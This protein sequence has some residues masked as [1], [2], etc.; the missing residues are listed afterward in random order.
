LGGLPA[1]GRARPAARG[2][3]RAR[4]GPLRRALGGA[5]DWRRLALVFATASFVETV[6][7]GHF[8]TFLPLLVRSLG[9]TDA[10]LAVT[11]GILSVGA[12]IA[13]L[14]LVPFW[15]AWADRYSRK[16]V[17]VRSAAVETV[18]FLLLSRVG[19]VWQLFVLVPLAG[20]VLGNTG[21]M[22]S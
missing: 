1:H 5:S 2:R 20:L 11:V 7:F 3:H 9:V 16:A 6:S 8:L 10:G 14:P 15:G 17:I 4:R 18:L 22:L 13:G 21:V 19:E 12:F